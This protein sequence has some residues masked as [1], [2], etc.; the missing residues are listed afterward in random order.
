MQ[1]ASAGDFETTFSL[2]V[3]LHGLIFKSSG[4]EILERM[5]Y[6]IL[7]Q[8]RRSSCS[9]PSTMPNNRLKRP[10]DPAQLAKLMVDILTA[11]LFAT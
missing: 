3:N 2:H 10:R 8:T 6:R 1:A 4:N 9:W 11:M 5:G 7:G